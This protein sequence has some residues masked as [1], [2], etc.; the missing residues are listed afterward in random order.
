M[1]ERR[2]GLVRVRTAQLATI[3]YGMTVLLVGSSHLAA[4]APCGPTHVGT[5]QQR[6]SAVVTAFYVFSDCEGVRQ[7]ELVVAWRGSQPG[8]F[9]NLLSDPDEFQRYQPGGDINELAE[10]WKSHVAASIRP[11]LG[12]SQAAAFDGF[13][14]GTVYY[15]D[16]GR[17][18]LV[19]GFDP[20]SFDVLGHVDVHIGDGFQALVFVDD[21]DGDARV[22]EALSLPAHDASRLEPT[23]DELRA[24]KNEGR[25]A[26][27]HDPRGLLEEIIA[28]SELGADFLSGVSSANPRE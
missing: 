11:D 24:A 18:Y 2:R 20:P 1:R 17:W 6:L 7:V 22:V 3:F 5:G 28:S 12:I 10:Q 21:A 26:A 16:V 13:L 27:V 25:L 14:W 23:L 4:Q 9:D 15:P 19:H 8:W